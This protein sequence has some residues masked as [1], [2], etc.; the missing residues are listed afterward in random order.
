MAK[1]AKRSGTGLLCILPLILFAQA[2][3]A[4]I[5][6]LRPA[7]ERAADSL[8]L[9]S[10]RAAF[11]QHKTIPPGIELQ[12]LRALS[13]YP[14]LRETKVTFV[15]CKQKTAHS[16]QPKFRSLLRRRD[17]RSYQIRISVDVPEFYTAGMQQN[18]PYNAQ[19]G[20]LG[21]ELGHTA[22]YLRKNLF[23]ILALGLRY[24]TSKRYV[25]RMEHQTDQTAIDHHLGWQLLTW[26]RIARPLLEQAGRAQNYMRPEEI[27]AR[28]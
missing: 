7:Y 24:G 19:I 11:G 9:D 27:E 25:I 17:Q 8:V 15:L 2:M 21:H 10:L 22:H 13:H 6:P 18:L 26:A 16:S 14:E 12:A 20:V 23:G 4:Q 1:Q 28:L 3:S 5:P